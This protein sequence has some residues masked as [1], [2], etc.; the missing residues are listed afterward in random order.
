MKGGEAEVLTPD[1][2]N[3]ADPRGMRY[4]QPGSEG[5]DEQ[6]RTGK[7]VGSIVTVLLRGGAR[8]IIIKVLT[9]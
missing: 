9:E 1:G 8:P 3:E 4:G 6:K 5:A 7:G 2:G